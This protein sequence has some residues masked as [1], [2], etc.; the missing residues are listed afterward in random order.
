[1]LQHEH[2]QAVRAASTGTASVSLNIK[3]MKQQVNPVLFFMLREGDAVVLICV[4]M[5]MFRSFF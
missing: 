3:V 4:M 5:G 1:V 2:R